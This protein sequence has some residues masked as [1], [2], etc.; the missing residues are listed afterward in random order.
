[1]CTLSKIESVLASSLLSLR[2]CKCEDYLPNDFAA[3][4][5]TWLAVTERGGAT[6]NFSLSGRFPAATCRSRANNVLTTRCGCRASY[7]SPTSNRSVTPQLAHACKKLLMFSICRKDNG[8]VLILP[9]VSGVSAFM[10]LPAMS[11][12]E[13]A[14]VLA[15]YDAR[16]E[17]LVQVLR[18]LGLRKFNML[19]HK[20]KCSLRVGVHCFFARTCRGC[21]DSHCPQKT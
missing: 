16:L 6:G 9:I 2:S 7:K 3:T 12:A 8:L 13:V 4:N 21:K 17:C 18:L 1:M 10:S 19:S 20:L 5:D 14:N 15:K 11:H